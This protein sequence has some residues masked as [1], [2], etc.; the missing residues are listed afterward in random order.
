MKTKISLA[1]VAAVVLFASACG[2]KTQE[3]AS[4]TNDTTKVKG[5]SV[6]ASVAGDTTKTK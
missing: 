3:T 1:I 4:T 6:S 2:S 5:D